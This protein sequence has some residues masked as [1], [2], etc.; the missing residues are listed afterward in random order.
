M[1]DSTTDR[2]DIEQI[3]LR[4]YSEKA[5][6]DYAMY[7][8]HDRALPHV[9]DGLKPVQRRIVYAMS[10]LSLNATAKP[11]KSARTIGDV[12]GKFHPHGD[13][14]CYEAMVLMAQNFS[15]RYPLVDGQGNWGAPDDPKSFA[16]MRYT[17]ARLSP[18]ADLLLSELG[19]GT[20]DVSPNFDATL[21][22]PV[23]LPARV[24][25]V[26][27]NGG[28]G[29]A[30]GMAT[31]IPPHNL[32]EVVSA[33]I[34]LLS[35]P[36]A[37][38]KALME[39]V[40][41]PD[42]PTEAEIITPQDEILKAYEAGRGSIRARAVYQVEGDD[43]IVT[44]LPHQVSP[45]RVLE[46]IAGQMQA[47]KLPTVV[48]L[49]DESDHE[50]PTRLVIVRRSNRVNVERLMSHLYATTDLER[51][52]RM[53]F[54]VIA[55]DGRPRVMGLREL[56]L[57][58]LHF[59][60]ETVRRRLR[61]RLERIDQ[62]LHLL[63]GLLVAYVN[64]DEVIRI[65]RSE[66]HPR[67]FLMKKFKLSEVQASAILDLRL[68][69]LAR[70]EQERL[71]QEREELGGE[72][73]DIERTLKSS[74]RLRTMIEGELIGD[75]E[76][77]GDERRSVLAE[78]AE[79]Q[80]YTEEELVGSEPVTIVLSQKGWVRAARGHDVESREL[81]FRSG[82]G[83]LASVR[84]RT[85][86][87]VI[88][89]DSTGRAY[90]VAAHT[91]PSARGQGEPLSGRLN[92][93]SGAEFAGILMGA[94]DAEVLL[95]SSA[96]YGF[97]ARLEAL[98][99]KNRSGKTVLTVPAGFTVVAPHPIKTVSQDLLVAVTSAGRMLVFALQE[100][101]R[102][103]R[104]KGNK[105]VQLPKDGSE[106]LLAAMPLAQ[107]DLLVIHAGQRYLKLRIGDLDNYRGERGRRGRKLPRGFQ[108]V[109]RVEVTDRDPNG[110]S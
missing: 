26:L 84:G 33:C 11:M 13:S 94:P 65:V 61:Y 92:P 89:L 86:Q 34:R 49:R 60:K 80:A 54:N 28:T 3:P 52:Y 73:S 22:E 38:T 66:E 9:A 59:R 29:I 88:F 101:P 30:V 74:R 83:Y 107:A 15:F 25:T 109:D 81:G 19:Q 31:D 50:N 77:F 10:E 98:V 96:G 16:A 97:V 41:C 45:A 55:L 17:E 18:F 103:S 5:Y 100:L 35:E 57:E 42:F 71:E 108:R 12:L 70:L 4:V 20:V 68:R 105:I 62:R 46:Q 21:T 2:D 95:A 51:S 1:S 72:K 85:N 76:A 40:Q 39:H 106:H 27:L 6:L 7:V 82:D 43:I 44:A 67:Q 36:K 78:G 90:T 58:W 48:D 110:S 93:P 24:P 47:R 99:S 75:A 14:A 91:L 87:A 56:L 37:T 102:L 79:A 104:G 32:R 8:I 63:E 53:N 69:Q 64:L 23:V